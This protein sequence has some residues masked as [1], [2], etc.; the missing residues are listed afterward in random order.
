MWDFE[1]E[2]EFQVLLDWT[3]DFV[4]DEVTPLDMLLE[5]PLDLSDPVRQELVPPLQ[6]QV[7]ERGLWACHLDPDL[8]GPGYGQ[9][10]LALL[11][12]ILGRSRCAPAVFGSQA[13]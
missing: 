6:R 5:D 4:R 13:P 12:E 2:P 7:K 8:G 10:K 9:L 3:A 1:T 11:N